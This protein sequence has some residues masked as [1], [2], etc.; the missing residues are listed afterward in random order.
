MRLSSEWVPG[1]KASSVGSF[2]CG[3]RE[4]VYVVTS[5]SQGFD[6]ALSDITE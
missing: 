4:M 2:T 3:L 5:G 1:V 6:C